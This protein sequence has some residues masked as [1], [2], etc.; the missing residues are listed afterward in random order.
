M[1]ASILLEIA[2][3]KLIPSTLLPLWGEIHIEPGQV[4]EVEY[5]QVEANNRISARSCVLAYHRNG[6]NLISKMTTWSNTIFTGMGRCCNTSFLLPGPWLRRA[7]SLRIVQRVPQQ[8]IPVRW[9]YAM[10]IHLCRVTPEVLRCP[11]DT[12][13]IRNYRILTWYESTDCIP[14]IANIG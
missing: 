1:Y 12:T 10:F 11:L 6:T 2:R 9:L 4:P 8:R 13:V 7:V 14:H 5:A 3:K